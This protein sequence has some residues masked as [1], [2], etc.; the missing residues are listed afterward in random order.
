MDG[1]EVMYC[2]AEWALGRGEVGVFVRCV[3]VLEV[4]MVHWNVS[5][6]K[7]ALVFVLLM[8]SC[9]TVLTPNS[10]LQLLCGNSTGDA[11]C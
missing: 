8:I 3:P 7:P 1:I 6:L 10:A 4:I 5:V 9:F 2:L 11:Q